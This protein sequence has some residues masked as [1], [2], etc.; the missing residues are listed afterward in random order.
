MSTNGT[1]T[2]VNSEYYRVDL[3]QELVLKLFHTYY[4]I[5]QHSGK[6]FDELPDFFLV[7]PAALANKDIATRSSDKLIIDDCLQRAT[8]RNGYVGVVKHRNPKLN[9]F[10][11]GLVP[12]PFMLGDLVTEDNEASFF[13]VLSQFVEYAKQNPKVYGDIVAE[14]DSDKDLALMLK[15]INKLGGKLHPLLSVY[16]E[17]QLVAF[18]RSWPVTEVKK[19]LD[20]LKD[21]EQSWCEVFFEYLIYVMGHKTKA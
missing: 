19:L 3:N 18:N 6:V 16:S 11:L 8:A 4:R 17:E 1:P 21:N 10:W 5:H 20:A 2:G 7:K 13:F 9:Y 14:I 12:M 15:E